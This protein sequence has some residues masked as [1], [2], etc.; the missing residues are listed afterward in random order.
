MGGDVAVVPRRRRST[1]SR[2]RSASSAACSPRTSVARAAA[3]A[4]ADEL[5]AALLFAFHTPYGLPFGTLGLEQAVQPVVVAARAPSRVATLS[6]S[7]RPL[8]P[9]GQPGLRGRRPAS[10][11]ICGTCSGRRSSRRRRCTRRLLRAASSAA[12][13]SSASSPPPPPRGGRPTCRWASA[14]CSPRD[15]HLHLDR[16]DPRRARGLAVRYL[17]SSG[18]SPGRTDA[19]MRQCTTSPSTRSPPPRPPRRP[20]AAELRTSPRGTAGPRCTRS[21]WTPACWRRMLALGARRDGDRHGPRR[22]LVRTCI[23]MPPSRRAAS[24]PRSPSS[25]TRRASSPRRARGT[26]SAGTVRESL[27]VLAAHG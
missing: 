18:C 2:S 1:S 24:P 25:T 21:R 6:S 9:H 7:S 4:K 3:L 19:R 10:W 15:G 16:G 12:S 22:R 20:S 5:G 8:A 13:A 23:R 14:P 27:F 17:L 11:T 26:T